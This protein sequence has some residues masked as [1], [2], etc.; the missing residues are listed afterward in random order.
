M[1]RKRKLVGRLVIMAIAVLFAATSIL[2]VIA[3]VVLSNVYH[4][5]VREELKAA[6][7]H[8]ADAFDHQFDGD[9][10]VSANGELG[11][12]IT[13]VETLYGEQMDALHEQTGIDYT[14]FYDT[15]SY[16]STMTKEDSQ[17]ERAIGSEVPENVAVRCLDEGEEFY[18]TNLTLEGKSYYGYYVPLT[19]INGDTVGMVFAGRE[20]SDIKRTITSSATI[21]ILVVLGFVLVM[22]VGGFL[23]NR[24]IS[25]VMRSIVNT[26]ATIAEG[27]LNVTIP[28]K[29]IKRKDELGI[30][31][32]STKKLDDELAAIIDNAKT[33]SGNVTASGEELSNS[34]SMATTE[35]AHVTHAVDDIST[36]AIN[37]ASRVETSA[38]NTENI[39]H[40]I[41]SITKN[42]DELKHFS[43]NL[44]GLC[45]E[46]KH[47]L[48]DV[49]G[50]NADVMDEMQEINAQIRSTND[51][52]QEIETASSL[53]AN[54]ADQTNLLALNASIEAAR[55]GEAGKGFAVV[56]TEIGALAEQSEEATEEIRKIIN[57]LVTE[58][59]L[60][61]RK[62]EELNKMVEIQ[63]QKLEVTQ[64]DM[65][66][67]ERGARSVS[68]S[69]DNIT[70]CIQDL[71]DSKESLLDIINELS[72]ISEQNA[73]SSEET[74]A[75][76][77]KL[78]L[79]FDSISNSAQELKHMSEK[80]DK[81]MAYFHL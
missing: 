67:M 43:E 74:N 21:M 76:M 51:S 16:L 27:N 65:E 78:N 10:Y 15:T 34:V 45:N 20:S 28:D 41:E 46:V 53:I 39:G 25:R 6:A 60:S 49:A 4:D 12:G 7:V 50:Q 26:L 18:S 11:K 62:L 5:M 19:K 35:S 79:T 2:A 81:E 29:V 32:E 61:V 80:L 17:D 42:V 47:A 55:A 22:V 64:K 40:D 31:A 57:E 38:N 36:G 23:I 52:V 3:M 71:N 14:V 56:A 58:S 37:Q 54:I 73:A 66:D 59:A 70:S 77:E 13:V 48:S 69:S 1:K 30:I 63:N 44:V 8:L 33:L 9:W 75:S 24:R 72:A 68:D